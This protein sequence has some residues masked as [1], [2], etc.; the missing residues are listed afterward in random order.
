MRVRASEE[1]T[2]ERKVKKGKKREK[3]PGQMKKQQGGRRRADRNKSFGM[4]RGFAGRGEETTC[5]RIHGKKE[6]TESG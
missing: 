3:G 4:S 2:R 5:P 6:R 1:M